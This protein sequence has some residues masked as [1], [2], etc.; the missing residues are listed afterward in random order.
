M[1]GLIVKWVFI[2]STLS[3]WAIRSDP[4]I[5]PPYEMNA[6]ANYAYSYFPL[7]SNAVNPTT[8]HSF[9]NELLVGLEGS[10]SANWFC[11]LDLEFNN[12]RKVDFNLL[13]VAPCVKYQMLN[14]LAGDPIALLVGT[15]FRYV[16]YNRLVDV[17]MSYNGE[18]NFDFLFSVGKEFDKKDKLAGKLY[19]LFDVGVA[20]KGMPWILGDVV[21]EAIFLEQ[22]F[23]VMGTDGYF[24][25]GEQNTVNVDD[26]SGYANINHNSL[27]IKAG[28]KYKFKVW[29]EAG[30]LYKRRVIAV[31]YPAERDYF[32]VS[33]NL[34]FSF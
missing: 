24:G 7:V 1:K 31:A 17:A 6:K 4:W 5:P 9:F 16:P 19:A 8:Y 21:G 13:S 23:F 11:E 30:F 22:H 33:Y 32:G 25:F 3:L 10:L 15:Y 27:E 20:T 18:Y 12:S 2:L 29:G 34:D 28:Y 26:F 14:D